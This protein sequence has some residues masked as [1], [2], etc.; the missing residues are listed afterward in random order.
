MRLRR[1]ESSGRQV[2]A[3]WA[4]HRLS[5]LIQLTVSPD[6][7][8]CWVLNNQKCR[9]EHTL[10]EELEVKLLRNAIIP[11]IDSLPAGYAT[12]LLSGKT[13]IVITGL[14]GS[15]FSCRDTYL[16]YAVELLQAIIFKAGHVS[17]YAGNC[18]GSFSL[19]QDTTYHMQL[20]SFPWTECWPNNLVET[21]WANWFQI[22]P[23]E[24]AKSLAVLFQFGETLLLIMGLKMH[25][26]TLQHADRLCSIATRHLTWIFTLKVSKS[27][28]LPEDPKIHGTLYTELLSGQIFRNHM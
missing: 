21:W 18:F 22:S 25:P 19:Y 12:I 2:D 9:I 6:V 17:S 1:L 3:R 27:G 23:I 16:C 11:C 14:V 15:N 24:I 28:L 20:E 10:E 5:A 13:N 7:Y 26:Q 8:G 4:I